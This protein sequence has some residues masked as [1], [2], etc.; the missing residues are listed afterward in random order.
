MPPG[1]R[2]QS[3]SSPLGGGGRGRR[4]PPAVPMSFS[5]NSRWQ[6]FLGCV[7]RGSLPR[8][9]S[10]GP[11]AR[12]HGRGPRD[13]RGPSAGP[14]GSVPP[15]SPSGRPS[16]GGAHSQ[17]PLASRAALTRRG[18]SATGSLPSARPRPCPGLRGFRG[19]LQGP[20]PSCEWKWERPFPHSRQ[21]RALRP[22]TETQGGR[23]PPGAAP[24][25]PGWS[26]GPLLPRL[27]LRGKTVLRAETFRSQVS[28]SPPIPGPRG[29]LPPG[30]QG[31][32]GLGLNLETASAAGSG[33][34]SR[35][36]S[37][38]CGLKRRV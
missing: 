4:R 1:C 8:A 7:D 18:E 3:S 2:A 27:R 9:Q 5:G 36:G 25:M 29:P 21:T 35:A 38:V 19:A 33:A 15:C 17:E 23:W 10:A 32:S 31:L 37:R 13:G 14:G 26:L 11:G 6:R 28:V 24:C 12:V 34:R 30:S 16:C 22:V 20:R